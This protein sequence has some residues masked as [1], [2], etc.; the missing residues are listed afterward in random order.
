MTGLRRRMLLV[1]VVLS[2]V[3]MTSVA[4]L[5]FTSM[6][7]FLLQR[8][9]EQ[10]D[11]VRVPLG[12]KLAGEQIKEPPQEIRHSLVNIFGVVRGPDGRFGPETRLGA[13]TSPAD[14]PVL[15]DLPE[16]G[17]PKSVEGHAG[18][19]YR[20]AAYSA[21]SPQQGTL[22]VA[23]PLT[24]VDA[25][26]DRLFVLV[27][28]I[29]AGVLLALLAFALSLVRM[30]LRPLDEMEATATA[31]ASGEFHR[32]VAYVDK[33]TEVGR[34]GLALNT[35]LGR[36]EDAL[37]QRSRS[38]QRLRT[39]V[40][41]ASHELRTPLTS[42]L[43]Y[44]QMFHRGAADDPDDL[45]TVMRR[46][47]DESSR[48]ARLV[49]DLLVLARLDEGRPPRRAEV[50]VAA[51]CRDAVLDAGAH[52]P[53]RVITGP[54]DEPVLVFADADQLR[55]VLANLLRN[56]VKHTPPGTPVEVVLT[57]VGGEITID[58]VDHGPG[59]P[60][61]YHE[62]VF[63]RF[64]RVAAGRERD[65]GG[66]GLGL[67]IA[68]AVVRAHGGKISVVDTPDGGATFRL[69]LSGETRFP[70]SSQTRPSNG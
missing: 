47:E 20:L 13:G 40:A 64:F 14:R 21:F 31:I 59:I 67:S 69:V 35:M 12:A 54:G 19:R 22:Y 11:L 29:T 5:I 68:A 28:V 9:D 36:I 48:M 41:D 39:F 34:L 16:I 15:D 4:T 3:A 25:T 37:D 66:A 8:T 30:G 50:D 1:M 43:G 62:R 52:E 44:A 23:I 18:V 24:D 58:V 65:S 2:A 63:D 6:R 46:I 42:I 49:E 55:Q 60:A 38:E 27:V 17:S 7:S 51:L 70:G 57:K 53:G 10:L 56:A 61:E 45:H 26:L 32:R 33:T